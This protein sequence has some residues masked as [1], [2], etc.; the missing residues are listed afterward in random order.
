MEDNKKVNVV[1][2]RACGETINIPVGLKRTGVNLK[3]AIKN[4]APQP[5]PPCN[6]ICNDV[7][8]MNDIL[9]VFMEE[10]TIVTR[11]SKVKIEYFFNNTDP[12]GEKE[13]KFFDELLDILEEKYDVNIF[14]IVEEEEIV[15]DTP[16]FDIS[17]F[18]FVKEFKDIL[19]SFEIVI[20]DF[21]LTKETVY[22]I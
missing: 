14:D 19:E 2:K 3:E 9:P 5:A 11:I 4:I 17:D 22:T 7:E 10:E 21:V 6:C 13:E 18:D 20:N 15:Y 8:K 16:S 1:I 12:F